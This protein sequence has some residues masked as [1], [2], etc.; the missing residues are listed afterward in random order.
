MN[1]VLQ[2]AKTEK[3]ERMSWEVLDWNE[4]AIKFYESLGAVFY[5]DWWLCRLFREDLERLPA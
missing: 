3:V 2:I 5:K 1:Q 4:P